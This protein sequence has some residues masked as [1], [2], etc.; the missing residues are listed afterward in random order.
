MR[1][2]Y[3]GEV[4]FADK[5]F[6]FFL[7]KI[8]EL[9]L[10]RNTIIVFISDHGHQLGE[11]DLTG[12]VA[13]GMYPELMDI[14]LLIRHPENV[15]SGE[16]IDEYVYNHDL[17]KTLLSMV[18]IET[19]HPAEGI[20]IWKYVEREKFDYRREYV[21]S[22]FANYVFYRDDEYWFISNR[23][24]AESKLYEIKSDPKL[25]KN[26]AEDSAELTNLAYQRILDDA[27][28]ALPK[29]E[30]PPKEAYEWY[31]NLYLF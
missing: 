17:L 13:W 3:K 4:T 9:N 1:S 7:Q 22:A 21:T 25:E 6:G 5:W 24:G 18:N 19:D 2:H 11:H 16:K 10:E 15:G 31:F 27:G 23:N 29:I 14:P 28:G 26:I 20:D 12:K 8:Y 30:A